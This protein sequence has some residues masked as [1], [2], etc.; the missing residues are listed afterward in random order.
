MSRPY[1]GNTDGPSKTGRRAGT[2]SLMALVR[3]VSKGQMK[4]YGTLAYRPMRGKPGVLSVHATGRAL[5]FGYSN[6]SEAERWMDVFVKNADLL[7]VE[8]LA[9]YYPAPGGRG[10]RCD[11][12]AWKSYKPG[13]IS[14]APGGKWLHLEIAPEIADDPKRIAEAFRTIFGS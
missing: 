13:E 6:R 14:G 11:R 10:W 2:E 8:Y 5:D 3:F 1:T 4:N 7:C 12:E 9:D